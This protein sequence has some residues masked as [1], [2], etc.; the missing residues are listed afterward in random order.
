MKKKHIF[1]A[2]ALLLLPVVLYGIWVVATCRSLDLTFS[3]GEIQTITNRVLPKSGKSGPVEWTVETARI[4]FNPEGRVT[5]T[6]KFSA[7][8]HDIHAE[9]TA[10]GSGVLE[11][12][13]MGRFFIREFQLTDLTI[14]G[15]KAPS[16]F[17]HLVTAKVMEILASDEPDTVR[18]KLKQHLTQ[19]I[20]GGIRTVLE[21]RPVKTLQGSVKYDLAK[22]AIQDVVVQDGAL[23]VH[24]SIGQIFWQLISVVAASIMAAVIIMNPEIFFLAVVCSAFS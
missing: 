7:N 18:G 2:I 22:I 6:A 5:T 9:G 19:T 23:V 4:G 13:R 10:E 16:G 20:Q 8:L 11:Y 12:D 15:M 24:L 21:H 1:R 3:Q 17:R 14:S